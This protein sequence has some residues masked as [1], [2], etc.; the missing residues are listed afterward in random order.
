MTAS[1][2]EEEK[3]HGTIWSTEDCLGNEQKCAD[4]VWFGF[5]AIGEI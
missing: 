4:S 5:T 1:G 2:K 3:K